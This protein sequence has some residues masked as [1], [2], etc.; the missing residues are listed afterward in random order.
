MSSGLAPAISVSGL[1][2][3]Y[4]SRRAVDGVSFGV[5][6]GEVFVLLGPNGAGKTTTIEVLEGY[7]TPDGGMVRVLGLD[8]RRD[9]RRLKPRIGLMLQEGGLH[10]GIRVEEAVRLFSAFYPNPVPADEA[11]AAAGLED[12]A[13]ST[14]R[15]LSGGLYRR[16]SMAL[17]LIGRPEVVFLDEPTAGMDPRARAGALETIRGLKAGGVTVLLTT[18][19]LPEAEALADRVGIIDRG[20]LV[21]LGT[22]ASLA[23]EPGRLA[24]V[25]EVPIDA[26]ALAAELGLPTVEEAGPCAYALDLL[27]TPGLIAR[28]AT[29]MSEHEVLLVELRAGRR[30]LEEIFLRLTEPEDET[31]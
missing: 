25:T 2:K 10:P 21:A 26:G 8:P 6:T 11:I 3:V 17:A 23:G 16:L 20:V 4:G 28:L 7:R 12:D 29:W 15:Q 18:H 30:S 14:V 31:S 22:P 1:V 19:L 13:R 9:A 27:P 5:G 24:F